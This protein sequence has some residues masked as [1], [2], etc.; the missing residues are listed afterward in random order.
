MPHCTNTSWANFAQLH[1]ASIARTYLDLFNRST[2]LSSVDRC[3]L[4]IVTNTLASIVK[5]STF[6]DFFFQFANKEFEKTQK[7][8]SL[9]NA[10]SQLVSIDWRIFLIFS[11]KKWFQENIATRKESRIRR[12]GERR[13]LFGGR[14]L[15]SP[16]RPSKR[17]EFT[18]AA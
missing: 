4:R 8:S 10:F 12:G 11:G 16:L 9:F 13:V 2:F 18:E 6:F 7:K 5:K 17:V 15:G 1:R 14:E 3:F